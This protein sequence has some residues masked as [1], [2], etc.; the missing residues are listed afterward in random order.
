[1]KTITTSSVREKLGETI[2]SVAYGGERVVILRHGKS[3]AAL[4]STKDL[5][6][7][8]ALEDIYWAE[9]AKNDLAEAKAKGEK[10][11]SW[12]KVKAKLGL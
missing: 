9:L 2:N 8:E 10:P 3:A 12:N 6:V 1:M 7:L 11:V 5:E 4:I